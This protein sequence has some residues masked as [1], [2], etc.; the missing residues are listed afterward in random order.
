MKKLNYLSFI[1]FLAI[2]MSA[3]VTNITQPPKD[4][5]GTVIPVKDL[6]WIA[7]KVFM[8]ETSGNYENLVFW[9]PREEFLSLGI[10]HFIWYPEGYSG[11][12]TE[13]F[14]DLI[15]YFRQHAEPVPDWLVSQIERGAP[16]YSRQHF[17]DARHSQQVRDLHDL[18]SRTMNLQ[19]NFMADRLEKALPEISS[20]LSS[21]ERDR[22]IAHYRAVESSHRGLYPLLD[23]VNFKGEGISSTER[24]Q[25]QGWGLLQVL[26]EMR[27]VQAG[28]QALNEFTR[29]AELVLRRRVY[30]A[31]PARNED[32]FLPGWMHRINT[33][34]PASLWQR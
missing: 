22:V 12:Y 10:A 4:D 16:W 23:Y 2:S 30:N 18:M 29:A 6:S 24:Y 7:N 11:S 1:L 28:D 3:C 32:R 34:R 5:V 19:A 20:H 14:P 13:T 9:S 26:R 8:N 21:W 27:D 31:P 25:G 33:Y 17:V 15:R